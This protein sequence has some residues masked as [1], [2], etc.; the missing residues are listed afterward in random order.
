MPTTKQKSEREHLVVPG[1]TIRMV[2]QH[3]GSRK[4]KVT[5]TEHLGNEIRHYIFCQICREG[6]DLYLENSE[7][8]LSVWLELTYPYAE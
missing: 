4:L 6:L 8:Q 7:D 2:C 1:N 5:G 3:C